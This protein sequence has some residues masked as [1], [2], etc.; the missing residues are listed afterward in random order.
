MKYVKYEGL[1]CS[2]ALISLSEILIYL[3]A[4]QVNNPPNNTWMII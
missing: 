4:L 3:E 1:A 2:T